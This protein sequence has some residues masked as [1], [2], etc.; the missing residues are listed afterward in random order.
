[1]IAVKS[2]AMSLNPMAEPHM[3]NDNLNDC[4]MEDKRHRKEDVNNNKDKEQEWQPVAKNGTKGKRKQEFA[5]IKNKNQHEVLQD[6]D[7]DGEEEIEDVI[8]ITDAERKWDRIETPLIACSCATKEFNKRACD[9]NKFKLKNKHKSMEEDD[10]C[11]GIAEMSSTSQAD[12]MIEGCDSTK[13]EE[14]HHRSESEECARKEYDEL[15]KVTMELHRKA[16]ENK[17]NKNENE[18]EKELDR[19]ADEIVLRELCSN[20]RA[21]L[22]E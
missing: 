4:K 22:V 6:D 9:N 14:C 20:A 16:N 17:I 1:M 2:D 21:A 3:C 8:K 19:K 13:S 11:D 7:D 15:M 12:Q 5:I 18:N 10:V